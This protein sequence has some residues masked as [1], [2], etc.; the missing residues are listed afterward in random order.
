VAV[1]EEGTSQIH[2]SK[3]LRRTFHKILRSSNHLK[4]KHKVM[5]VEMDRDELLS[6]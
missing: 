5:T 2:L 1:V 3:D 6:C 4:I